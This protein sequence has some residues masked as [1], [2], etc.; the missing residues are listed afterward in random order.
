MFRM[1]VCNMTMMIVIRVLLS[2]IFT[3]SMLTKT[4]RQSY[5]LSLSVQRAFPILY[6]S[7]APA[8]I[9]SLTRAISSGVS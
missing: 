7:K 2:K 5:E 3:L 8:L 6:F 9:H 4:Q 1:N